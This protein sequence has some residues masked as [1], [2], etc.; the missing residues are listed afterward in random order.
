MDNLF[1]FAGSP[2]ARGPDLRDMSRINISQFVEQLA[3]ADVVC[4]VSPDGSFVVL[5]PG[6]SVMRAAEDKA[7]LRY[8]IV[9]V[10]NDTQGDMLA[11]VRLALAAGKR[12][13]GQ[14]AVPPRSAICWPSAGKMSQ[15]AALTNDRSSAGG[16]PE[17]DC[18]AALSRTSIARRRLAKVVESLERFATTVMRHFGPA[19]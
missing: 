2:L 19:G 15:T 8:F 9:L 6:E 18:A 11:G 5:P 17:D 1:D 16:E 4:C 12:C 7:S 10:A 13:R 14:V 3:E